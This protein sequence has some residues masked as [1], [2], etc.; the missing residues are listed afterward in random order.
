[1]GVA[2]M[3]R[4]VPVNQRPVLLLLR[5]LGT[6]AQQSRSASAQPPDLAD[7]K[8][9]RHPAHPQLRHVISLDPGPAV[10]GPDERLLHDVLGLLETAGDREQLTDQARVRRLVE[11]LEARQVGLPPSATVAFTFH[12]TGAHRG[13]LHALLSGS[14]RQPR[15]LR[16]WP[17]LPPSTARPACWPW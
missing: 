14:Q 10:Q 3:L 4:R 8:V 13:R 15:K 9:D 6:Q 2:E 5:A 17:C 16:R 7:R 11:L 12:S 1:M